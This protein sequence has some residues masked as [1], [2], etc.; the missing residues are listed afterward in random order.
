MKEISF[1]EEE[2]SGQQGDS[3]FRGEWAVWEKWA[4]L[5]ETEKINI[6]ERFFVHSDHMEAGVEGSRDL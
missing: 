4:G 1:P 2:W 6:N 3:I 5:K